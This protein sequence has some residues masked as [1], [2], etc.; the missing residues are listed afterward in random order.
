FYYFL[1]NDKQ[2]VLEY[3]VPAVQ[4]T[5]LTLFE[6]SYDMLEN[7]LF[8]VPQRPKDMIPKPFVVN[9]AVI[10]KKSVSVGAIA[11]DEIKAF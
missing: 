6:I 9:D 5:K 4:D 3:T 7:P 10:I 1:A 11:N 2:M 8:D